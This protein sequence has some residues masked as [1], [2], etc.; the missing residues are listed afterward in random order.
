MRKRKRE[1][2][3]NRERSTQNL[4]PIEQGQLMKISMPFLLEFKGVDLGEMCSILKV[5]STKMYEGETPDAILSINKRLRNAGL[6]KEKLMRTEAV[7][8]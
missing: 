4:N 2:E 5:M 3:D 1:G 8:A 6:Q 7:A